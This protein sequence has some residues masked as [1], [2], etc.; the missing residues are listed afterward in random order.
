MPKVK[1][2]LFHKSV[3]GLYHLGSVSGSIRMEK[4]ISQCLELPIPAGLENSQ[5]PS[6]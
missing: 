2:L 4:S 5:I 3:T 1:Y 6:S